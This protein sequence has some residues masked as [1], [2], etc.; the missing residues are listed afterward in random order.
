MAVA[1]TE[2]RVA[3]RSQVKLGA[4]LDGMPKRHAV[5]WELTLASGRGDED[6]VLLSGQVLNRIFV[7]CHDGR[8]QTTSS[9][10]GAQPL[11]QRL[12]IATVGSEENGERCTEETLA[13]LVV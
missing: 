1:E 11:S 13:E 3:D 4:V 5:H 9:A 7:Q 8:L 10:P 2:D 6:N 12:S